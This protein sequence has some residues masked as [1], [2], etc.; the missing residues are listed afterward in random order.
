VI[1][2]GGMDAVAG[3]MLKQMKA[4][5]MRAKLVSGDGVCSEKLPLLAGDALGDDKVFCVVAG[6]VSGAAGSRLRTPSPSATA[7][8]SR[9]RCRPMRRMPT[10]RDGVRRRR[11]CR[12]PAG[13]RNPV[14][15]SGQST[16]RRW[17]DF[18]KHHTRASPASASR[19]T[20]DQR[21][22]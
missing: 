8:A 18:I 22:T 17:R 1:F 14:R 21:A 7:S 4:L 11:R 9:S 20:P 16:C 5:G 19:S 6:G 12:I 3:P 2:Y 15:R 10:M 13:A